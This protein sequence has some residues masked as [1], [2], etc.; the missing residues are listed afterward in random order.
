MERLRKQPVFAA[1]IGSSILLLALVAAYLQHDALAA[2]DRTLGG[3]VAPWRTP[4]VTAAFVWLTAV[5]AGPALT[6]VALVASGLLA[7]ADRLRVILAMW[8]TFLGAEATTWAIKYLVD[9]SRPDLVAAV[10]VSSPSFPSAHATGALAVYGF[11]AWAVVSGRP[12]APARNA[13]LFLAAVLIGLVG[14]S[15][16]ILGVHHPSDVVAGWL[17]AVF[18]LGLGIGFARAGPAT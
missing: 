1:A 15:R 11:V 18:W 5:G 10:E 9:R 8:I 12:A 13:T 6:A 14:L 3:L 16:V 17:V 4:A 2:L 7:A